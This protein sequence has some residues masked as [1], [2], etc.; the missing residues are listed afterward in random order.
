MS[1]LKAIE[2]MATMF[3]EDYNLKEFPATIRFRYYKNMRRKNRVK[4]ISKRRHRSY[5]LDY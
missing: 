1:D 2:Y 4:N 5:D 3:P